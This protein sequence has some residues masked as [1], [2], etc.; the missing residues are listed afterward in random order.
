MSVD[1]ILDK[2]E[3]VRKFGKGWR[4][5]CPACGSKTQHK[6]SIKE[7][8]TGAVLIRCW[9]GC[10]VHQ[11][12]SALGLELTDLFPPRESTGKPNRRAFSSYEAVRELG[13]ELHVAWVILTDV[14]KGRKI[15]DASRRRAGEAAAKCAHLINMMNA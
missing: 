10:D 7:S 5:C 3:K 13:K 14:S 8:D 15:G 6:L 11:I 1:T 4:A 2:L 9:G 12:T